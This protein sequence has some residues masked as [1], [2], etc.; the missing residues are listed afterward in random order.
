[1]F[2]IIPPIAY[3]RIS[4]RGEKITNVMDFNELFRTDLSQMLV[5]A[6]CVAR[7]FILYT[8]GNG[9]EN[10]WIHKKVWSKIFYPCRVQV[11]HHQNGAGSHLCV[12]PLKGWSKHSWIVKDEIFTWFS[13]SSVEGLVCKL[14]K[15]IQFSLQASAQVTWSKTTNQLFL[16]LSAHPEHRN[17]NRLKLARF[18]S[19]G[20]LG[21]GSVALVKAI[22]WAS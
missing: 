15:K 19:S 22:L 8:C 12:N 21:G 9:F 5:N 10:T 18:C 11:K 6:D 1:M 16:F 2:A 7:C 14:E 20:G 13:C 3:R 4:G 17:Q